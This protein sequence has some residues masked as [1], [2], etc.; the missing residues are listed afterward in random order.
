MNV[1]MIRAFC[2]RCGASL[3]VHV[4][5]EGEDPRICEG[6][7]RNYILALEAENERLRGIIQEAREAFAVG[8]GGAAGPVA[9]EMLAILGR[10]EG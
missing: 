2:P 7:V 8:W 5:P 3:R 1:S 6:A 9:A 10:E 4:V